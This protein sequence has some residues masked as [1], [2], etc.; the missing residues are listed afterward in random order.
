VEGTVDLFWP[1]IPIDARADGDS[2]ANFGVRPTI[3]AEIDQKNGVYLGLNA[4][5]AGFDIIEVAAGGGIY[6]NA[7]G[8]I[9]A[10]NIIG[11]S[12]DAGF[13]GR[14]DEWLW[15]IT[16]E[17]GGYVEG[18]MTIAFW[19]IPL[20]EYRWPFLTLQWEGEI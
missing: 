15:E 19:D 18:G 7:Q 10:K 17:L 14:W 13:Y 6:E 8:W 20:F 2:Y 11:Y 4:N 3:S 16:L 5:I 9:T 1:F 12:S